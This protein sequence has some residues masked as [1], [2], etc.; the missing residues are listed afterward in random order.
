[1]PKA[2][3]GVLMHDVQSHTAAAL[4]RLLSELKTKGYSVVHVV[5]GQRHNPQYFREQLFRGL[6]R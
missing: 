4:P 5:S 1:V 6:F 3:S 2:P